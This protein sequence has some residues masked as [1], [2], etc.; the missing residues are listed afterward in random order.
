[1]ANKATWAYKNGLKNT[2]EAKNRLKGK[3]PKFG[4]VYRN[5][6]ELYAERV[7]SEIMLEYILSV[8]TYSNKRQVNNKVDKLRESGIECE[9]ST[10]YP[11]MI[12]KR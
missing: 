7:F 10:S 9:P 5:G 11:Y 4:W 12:I 1:M 3:T 6:S 2:R 8:K